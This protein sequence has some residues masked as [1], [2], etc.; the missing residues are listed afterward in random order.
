MLS[1]CSDQQK[2]S[3]TSSQ[4][5]EQAVTPTSASTESSTTATT[6]YTTSATTTAAT[7]TPA[8]ETTEEPHSHKYTETVTTDPTCETDGVKT[9][10]CEC[11]EYYTEPITATGHGYEEY[12]YNNNATYT[13]DGTETSTCICGSTDTRTATGSRLEYTY[14][15]LDKT[16]Y[17]RSDVNVR[18]LPSTDGGKL[19][20]LSKAQKVHITGQCVQTNRY[21]LEYNGGTGSVSDS[22]L[23]D[24]KPSEETTAPTV[25]D[26]PK[27]YTQFTEPLYTAWYDGTYFYFY[28]DQTEQGYGAGYESVS[29]LMHSLSKE[30]SEKFPDG[31]GFSVLNESSEEIGVYKNTGTYCDRSKDEMHVILIKNRFASIE[32]IN[33]LHSGGY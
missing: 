2:T 18:D 7:D 16:M 9:F 13:A 33:P 8:E 29:E 1:S 27:E 21:R 6:E 14:T 25:S 32:E 22:Y 12:V 10:T 17:A 26:T 28:H 24:D 31:Y 20:G 4:T 15:D 11:G 30:L 3:D 5:T 19:G 23:T